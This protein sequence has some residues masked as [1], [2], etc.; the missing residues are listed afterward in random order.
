MVVSVSSTGDPFLGI[1]QKWLGVCID[2]DLGVPYDCYITS[3]EEVWN[4]HLLSESTIKL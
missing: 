4:V 3:I 2:S 1:M